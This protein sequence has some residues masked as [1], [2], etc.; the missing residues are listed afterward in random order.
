MPVTFS[1]IFGLK[2]SFFNLSVKV[3]FYVNYLS[4]EIISYAFMKFVLKSPLVTLAGWKV[5]HRKTCLLGTCKYDLIWKKG[6]CRCNW[7]SNVIMRPTWIRVGSKSNDIVLIR[8]RRQ[9]AEKLECCIYKQ[10]TPRTADGHLKLGEKQGTDSPW[11][12]RRSQ[13]LEDCQHLRLMAWNCER[14]FFKPL[15]LW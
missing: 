8:Q 10:G 6:L 1:F 11:A 9:R 7:V 2:V 5:S 3:K 15:S 12:S 14:N 4:K 13:P